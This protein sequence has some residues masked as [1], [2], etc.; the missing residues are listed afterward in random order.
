MASTCHV[1][2]WHSLQALRLQLIYQPASHVTT[3]DLQPLESCTTLVGPAT[4]VS[5]LLLC[6]VRQAVINRYGAWEVDDAP[7]VKVEVE[8]VEGTADQGSSTPTNRGQEGST[9]AAASNSKVR[10]IRIKVTGELGAN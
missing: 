5:C 9:A 8:E 10:C 3:V 1:A 2:M 6:V 7:P 4:S